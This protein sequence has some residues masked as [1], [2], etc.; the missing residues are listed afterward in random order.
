[1]AGFLDDDAARECLGLILE[2]A[3]HELDAGTFDVRGL[4]GSGGSG[5]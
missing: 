5:R 2:G 4:V 3:I 1:L